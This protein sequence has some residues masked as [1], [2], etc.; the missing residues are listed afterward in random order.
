MHFVVWVDVIDSMK[1]E[2]R[3]VGQ[4]IKMCVVAF[5]RMSIKRDFRYVA[6]CVVGTDVANITETSR[7]TYVGITHRTDCAFLVYK[8]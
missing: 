2:S 3:Q 8:I 5:A 7:D 6:P 4:L 1:G